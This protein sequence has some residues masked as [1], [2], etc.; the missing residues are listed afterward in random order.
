M[1]GCYDFCAHYEWTFAWL[2]R[3]GGHALVRDY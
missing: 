1:I 3:A 2:E